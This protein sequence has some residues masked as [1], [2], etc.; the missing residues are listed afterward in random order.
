MSTILSKPV[1]TCLELC[2][3]ILS[4]MG[5]LSKCNTARKPAAYSVQIRYIY[6]FLSFQ[7]ITIS[8]R[9]CVFIYASFYQVGP[10]KTRTDWSDLPLPLQLGFFKVDKLA[11]CWT[12]GRSDQCHTLSSKMFSYD[13]VDKAQCLA[14]IS[15]WSGSETHVQLINHVTSH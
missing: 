12:H 5:I 1:D 14:V 15:S 7:I 4:T 11:N 9:I 13:V 8:N 2:T 10:L 3:L 6:V